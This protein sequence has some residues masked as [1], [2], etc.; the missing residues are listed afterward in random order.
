MTRRTTFTFCLGQILL[1]V[2][3]NFG[4]HLPLCLQAIAAIGI[5]AYYRAIGEEE[6]E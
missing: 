4:C 6:T 2:T 1:E 3:Y 5:A